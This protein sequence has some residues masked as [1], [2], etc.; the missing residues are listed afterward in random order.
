[1]FHPCLPKCEDKEAEFEIKECKRI[2][3]KEYGL[4]INS[5]AF[6]NGDYT[7]REIV[8]AKKSGFKYCFT[9]DPGFNTIFTDPFRIKRLDSNDAENLDEFIVKTSGVQ[10]L[11]N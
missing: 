1:V 5:L 6:P 8:I 3:E 10:S 11:F 2:L 9:T 4:S 7:P